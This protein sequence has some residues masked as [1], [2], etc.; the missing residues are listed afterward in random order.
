MAEAMDLAII[1]VGDINRD[2]TSLVRHLISP[3]LHDQL[4]DLGCVG[5]VMCNFLD[6]A[7]RTVD[8][9]VNHRIMSIGLDTLARARHKLIATG[10][11]SRAPAL[12][13]AIRRIGCNTL[14]TDEPAARAL[15]DA[16]SQPGET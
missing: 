2:S 15:L 4:V 5:D 1:S 3:A 12:L 8:H 7:G 11:R 9:P 13:A 10:G 16:P 6:A 14:I